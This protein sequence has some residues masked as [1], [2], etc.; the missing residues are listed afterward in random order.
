MEITTTSDGLNN[1]NNEKWDSSGPSVQ[2]WTACCTT[3]W[4]SPVSISVHEMECFCGVLDDVTI[5]L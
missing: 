1:P 2:M 4:P 3:V 5:P